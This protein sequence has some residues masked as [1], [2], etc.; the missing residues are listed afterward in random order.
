MRVT[1]R[2]SSFS[3]KGKNEDLRAI[4]QT[5]GVAHLL[6][7]SVR[8]EG[9]TLRITAQLIDGKDG[10]HLWSKTYDR[11]LEAVFTMQEEIA[12]DVTSALSIRLD[13]G[14]MSRA[15]GAPRTWLPS[16]GTCRR[17]GSYC[18][19]RWMTSCRRRSCCAR[20]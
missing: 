10:A 12:R 16:T 20:P 11:G 18:R 17:A 5:L 1:G 15:R 19:A 13:V 14:E 4:A 3:F 6:E 8:K 9:R 7:G 2:T